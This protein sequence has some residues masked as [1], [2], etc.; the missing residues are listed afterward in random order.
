M[1]L[2]FIGLGAMGHA[3][4]MNLIRAGHS[5][6]VWNRSPGKADDLVALGAQEVATPAEAVGADGIVFTMVADDAALHEVV[7]GP[8]GFGE[9]LGADGIHVS[10]STIA[11]QTAQALAELHARQGAAYVAAPVFG[12]PDAAAA[13]KLW[14]LGAGPEAACKRVQSLLETLGQRV[15]PL[16]DDPA[17]AHALKL[18][19]N[20][21][22]M[23]AI[24]AMS[25]ATDLVE[26]YGLPRETLM[27]VLG[28]SIFPS[29]IYINY[30]AQIARR[31]YRE[32]RFRLALGLKDANLVLYAA[33]KAGVEMP[34]AQLAQGRLAQSVALGRGDWDWTAFAHRD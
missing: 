25:E 8:G 16:G 17:R 28:Q 14:V 12:R 20:F 11:P 1:E 13:A 31:D 7:T 2:G 19:G 21:L 4:A 23:G 32:A 34:V 3:M 18:A 29:P 24:E 9:R 33:G 27:E 6:R 30:G 15:F 10:M 26:H 22:I 5:L